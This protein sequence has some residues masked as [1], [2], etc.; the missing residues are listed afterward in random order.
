MNPMSLSGFKPSA[1]RGKWLKVNNLNHLAMD[2]PRTYDVSDAMI[3]R[4]Q[5]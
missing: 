5:R 2:A 3:L 4:L 1:V